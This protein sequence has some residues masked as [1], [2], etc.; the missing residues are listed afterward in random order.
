MS[1]NQFHHLRQQSAKHVT[2]EILKSSKGHPNQKEIPILASSI[3]HDITYRDY[4]QLDS[5]LLKY[6]KF[7]FSQKLPNLVNLSQDMRNKIK[8]REEEKRKPD[9]QAIN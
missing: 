7:I 2:F 3:L 4:N 9:N 1:S 5:K 6:D 8:E